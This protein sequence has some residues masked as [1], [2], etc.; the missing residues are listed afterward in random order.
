MRAGLPTNRLV[1]R[2]EPARRNIRPTGEMSSGDR[3]EKPVVRFTANTGAART[4]ALD[5]GNEVR[6]GAFDH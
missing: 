2:L 5:G 3:D 1:R 4:G 6:I